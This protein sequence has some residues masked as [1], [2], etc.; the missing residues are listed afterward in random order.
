MMSQ[1]G[2]QKTKVYTV[3]EINLAIKRAM[4][5]SFFNIWVEGEVSNFYFHNRRHMYFDLKD[6][7]SKIKVVMFYQNNKGLLFEIEDGMHLM[8]K[9]YVSL[10]EKRGEY[11]IIAT[12]IKPVGKGSLILAFEQ[13]KAKLEKK[14]YFK[15]AYKKIIPLLP[16][17]IGLVTSTGGAVIKDIISVLNRRSDSYHLLVRNVNVGGA[18]S[19]D[20]ICSAIDDL[21]DYEVDVIIL[22]RGG[23]SLEDLWGFNTE[24]LADKIFSCRIP[25]ISAV[26]HE[27]DFTICDFVADVR[28]ATPSVGA[29]LSILNKI[30]TAEQITDQTLRSKT[31]IL[32]KINLYK[33][34]LDY[35]INRKVFKHPRSLIVQKLQT[36]DELGANIRN[37][38]QYMVR[39]KKDRFISASYKLSGRDFLGRV[40]NKKLILAG[41]SS[42]FLYRIRE[43]M[44]RKKAKIEVLLKGLQ[45]SSPAAIIGKGY[46]ILYRE[47]K[48]ICLNSIEDV[49]IGE[50]IRVLLRDGIL[51]AQVTGKIKKNWR[52]ENE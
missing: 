23:G 38:G 13:L 18:A 11:Q 30:Q 6:E 48:D 39:S 7:H 40:K 17:R 12:D 49:S 34:E 8:A 46:G 26:G 15:K 45:T 28:A 36:L 14:G 9:G 16:E 2:L 20:D 44:A 31:I 42:D 22:A 19:C 50:I 27:T 52:V 4:E 10:Y 21:S 25:V 1:Q 3:S 33:R 35:L 32:S 51:L 47:K 43:Q 5:S 29:E 24:V 41:L 37:L